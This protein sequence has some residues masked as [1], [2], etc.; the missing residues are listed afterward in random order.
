[1]WRRAVH[2]DGLQL[3]HSTICCYPLVIVRSLLT[4]PAPVAALYLLAIP[5]F[6]AAY[7]F[8]WRD[9]QQ[10]TTQLDNVLPELQA[11]VAGELE[12][13]PARWLKSRSYSY[14]WTA[15]LSPYWYDPTYDATNH[16]VV[17]RQYISL[18]QHPE[19]DGARTPLPDLETW[20]LTCSV[21]FP[22]FLK[23]PE[24]KVEVSGIP[25]RIVLALPHNRPRSPYDAQNQIQEGAFVG[26]FETS[27]DDVTAN[28]ARFVAH[29][30]VRPELYDK[31]RRYADASAGHPPPASFGFVRYLYLSAVTL[32]TLGFGDMVPLTDR[33]R[34]LITV[35]SIYGVVMAGLFLNAI[36]LKSSRRLQPNDGS[37]A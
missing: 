32:T 24:L 36:A 1:M 27:S 33:A 28:D 18:T 20:P 12:Q 26:I 15:S 25:N 31:I 5:I 13:W 6:A 9:F 4:R 30:R 22:D 23:R 19:L 34:I 29:V 8:L 37:G 7:A 14:A 16:A 10:S 21:T 3:P 35:E 17:F 11:E 2:Q